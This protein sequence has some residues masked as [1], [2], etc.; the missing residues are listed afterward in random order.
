[1]IIYPDNWSTIGAIVGVSQVEDTIE[2][3]TK[4]VPCCALSLSGGV[5]SALL[6]YYMS[7]HNT[8][9]RA[10]TIGYSE[11]H[12]DVIYARKICKQFDNVKHV[13]HIPKSKVETVGCD[14]DGDE[15]VREFYKFVGSFEESIVTGD[16]IDEFMCGYYKHQQ[17]K[18]DETYYKCIRELFSIQL[19]PLNRNS[20]G[21]LVYLPYLDDRLLRLL[22][23]IPTSEKVDIDN[24]KKIIISIAKDKLPSSIVYRRKYGFCNAL[25]DIRESK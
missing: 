8:Q 25:N 4:D 21:V 18:T 24:R 5:D 7:K 17:D 15:A 6:L 12:P 3:V 20:G 13:V 11:N 14:L 2:Q 19:E 10:Y 23:M 22:V 1:V 9:V 16:G